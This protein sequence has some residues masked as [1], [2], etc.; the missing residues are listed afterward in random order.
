MAPELSA[1]AESYPW[2]WKNRTRTANTATSPPT[3]DVNIVRGLQGEAP[4]V[5]ELAGDSAD[6]CP[7]AGR[8]RQLGEHE[9]Q[10]YPAPARAFDDVEG[11]GNVGEHS[12]DRPDADQA[13]DAEQQVDPADPLG[14]GELG[15]L[16][17]G[18][19]LPPRSAVPGAGPC[20]CRRELTRDAG[21][22]PSAADGPGR[23]G[24]RQ[25]HR[26]RRLA[27]TQTPGGR[28]EA[29]VGR[30]EEALRSARETIPAGRRPVRGMPGPSQPQ[31]GCR[32][33]RGACRR[34]AW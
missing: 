32:S 31:H 28:P 14:L 12:D 20:C 19:R 25:V 22:A 3:S 26:G 2:R 34:A 4:P 6:R 27:P 13:P 16:D 10:R 1:V 23:R 17:S 24:P 29:A 11:S 8:H 33:R 21:R 15:H 18:R 9:R 5:R 7:R 30:R